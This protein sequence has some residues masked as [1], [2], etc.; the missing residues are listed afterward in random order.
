MLR[1]P[2][3]F[4]PNMNT[5]MDDQLARTMLGVEEGWAVINKDRS[6]KGLEKSI[7][8]LWSLKRG[9]PALQAPWE[10]E[11]LDAIALPMQGSGL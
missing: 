6:I 8:E 11:L 9:A 5:G 1:T 10:E 4:L 2:T 7:H 3:L